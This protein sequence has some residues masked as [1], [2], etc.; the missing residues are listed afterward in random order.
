M[1]MAIAIAKPL[2][3]PWPALSWPELWH[4]TNFNLIKAQG[5]GGMGLVG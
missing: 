4:V 2:A 5:F 1:A 3:S